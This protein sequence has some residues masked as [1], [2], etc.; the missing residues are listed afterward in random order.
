M[1]C[2]PQECERYV[3]ELVAAMKNNTIVSEPN[4]LKWAERQWSGALLDAVATVQVK[5]AQLGQVQQ[6]HLQMKIAKAFLEVLTEEK[7]K[8]SL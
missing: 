5:S 1:I 6:Y 8:T 2:L 4:A 3:Q 7:E